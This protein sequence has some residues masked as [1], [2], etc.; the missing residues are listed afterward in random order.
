MNLEVSGHMYRRMNA[1]MPLARLRFS[2]EGIW[3]GTGRFA[4]PEDLRS[5]SYRRDQVKQVFRARSV[6][7]FG[8]G[9]DTTDGMTHYFWTFRSR[10][11]IEQ[12]VEAGYPAGASRHARWLNLQGF[13]LFRKHGG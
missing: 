7:G 13:S 8:V 10:R 6:P 4:L 9:F 1:T 12:L 5:V 11:V 3:L 2:E